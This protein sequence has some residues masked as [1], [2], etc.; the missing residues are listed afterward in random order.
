M[1]AWTCSALFR[2]VD[3]ACR[4]PRLSHGGLN[5]AIAFGEKLVPLTR[6]FCWKE[7]GGGLFGLNVT[8]PPFS[9]VI[10]ATGLVIDNAAAFEAATFGVGLFTVIARMPGTA[11]VAAGTNAVNCVVEM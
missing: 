6:T 9:A 8:P 3:S 1:F 7:W 11:A 4:K 2:V 10:V 5:H